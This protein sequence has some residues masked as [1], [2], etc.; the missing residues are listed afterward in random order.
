LI[1]GLEEKTDFD[2][3]AEIFLFEKDWNTAWNYADKIQ[4]S[5]MSYS[6]IKLKLAEAFDKDCPDRAIKVYLDYAE[7]LI[8]RRGRGNYAEA[9][10]YLKKILNVYS[11][12]GDRKTGRKIIADIRIKYC[13]LPALRDEMN[14][15]E[16]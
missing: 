3:L 5:W 11:R 4:R 14:K 15:A 1:Q 6:D 7:R 16:L 12:I 9:A 10:S 2:L 8:N 13:K